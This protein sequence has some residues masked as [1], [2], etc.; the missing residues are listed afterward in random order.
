MLS[1]MLTATILSGFL[2]V[3]GFC[4]WIW[5]FS[6]VDYVVACTGFFVVGTFLLLNWLCVEEW[7]SMSDQEAML[8]E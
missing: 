1:L 5:S 4:F 3:F 2:T 8:T 6:M 7:K